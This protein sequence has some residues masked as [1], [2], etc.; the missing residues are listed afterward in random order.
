M[1]KKIKFKI[2]E[3]INVK[4]TVYDILGREIKTI[5]EKKMNPGV[6]EVDLKID[7]LPEGTY[8]YKLITESFIK[9]KM[10]NLLKERKQ[11]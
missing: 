5:L 11:T 8:Y 4:V 6:Y 3:M 7:S 1:S 2:P 9:T 10:F